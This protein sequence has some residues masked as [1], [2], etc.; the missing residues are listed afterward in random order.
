MNNGSLHLH[1]R[2]K[3]FVCYI[4]DNMTEYQLAGE[5]L[6]KEQVYEILYMLSYYGMCSV[7]S[8]IYSQFRY[9]HT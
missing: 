4:V 9:I 3:R 2:G 6:T 7:E 1:K 5:E 8:Y